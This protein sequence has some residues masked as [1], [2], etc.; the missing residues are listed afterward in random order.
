MP[1]QDYEKTEQFRQML[2]Q[3]RTGLEAPPKPPLGSRGRRKT[4]SF[5][6]LE[7]SFVEMPRNLHAASVAV[8][9]Q[10][11][12][13]SASVHP[14]L[15]KR[16]LGTQN[17]DWEDDRDNAG[18]AE[19]D[20]SESG[21][22]DAEGAVSFWLTPKAS[23]S[24]LEHDEWLV[25]DAREPEPPAPATTAAPAA[26]A[27]T[28][29]A[30]PAATV[31]AGNT[32]TSPEQREA[33]RTLLAKFKSDVLGAARKVGNQNMMERRG[34]AAA[35]N[36]TQK[37]YQGKAAA[38][39][40]AL[41]EL[42]R[43]VADGADGE[44][45]R[46]MSVNNTQ[47]AR[48]MLQQSLT[49]EMDKKIHFTIVETVKNLLEQPEFKAILC[50]YSLSHKLDEPANGKG[51][52][53][54]LSAGALMRRGEAAQYGEEGHT[55]TATGAAA[56]QEEAAQQR[57][58]NY[59]ALQ[60]QLEQMPVSQGMLLLKEFHQ[61]VCRCADEDSCR[62]SEAG[63][64]WCFVDNSTLVGCKIE[65]VKLL[66]DT[67]NRTWS[68][69]LCDKRPC[70]PANLGMKPKPSERADLDTERHPELSNNNTLI[71]YGSYCDTWKKT[72]K[73]MWAYV[74]FDT[75]CVERTRKL[76]P[77]NGDFPPGLPY[78]FQSWT[79]CT[80][81]KL[82]DTKR[83]DGTVGALYDVKVKC[84]WYQTVL[85]CFIIADL[86]FTV[87]MMVIMYYFIANRCADN[88]E[89]EESTLCLW[90]PNRSPSPRTRRKRQPHLLLLL[91]LL[92]RPKAF[93]IPAHFYFEVDA[94]V[95]GTGLPESI[96]AAALARAG[97][98][99]LH[100]D[101]SEN[102]GGPWR[103]LPLR[104]YASWAGGRATM[105]GDGV[106]A[107]G[108]FRSLPPHA[109]SRLY[110]GF[111]APAAECGRP[112]EVPA[113][114]EA[115]EATSSMKA[116]PEGV[117]AIDLQRPASCFEDRSFD[118]DPFDE[119]FGYQLRQMQNDLL[120]SPTSF[121]L[122]L[123]P[124]LLY[125][126]SD[127]VDVLIESG[128]ARYLE[129]QGLKFTRVLTSNG[130]ASVPLTKSEI[131]QDAH[132]SKAEKRLLMRFITSIQPFVSSL[133]FQS[134]A[135]LGVDQ[136]GKVK[137][138]ADADALKA[139]N[140][141][142]DSS[143]RSFLE[144]QSL[145]ER[146]QDFITYSICLWDWPS[147]HLSCREALGRMGAFIS[148]LGLYGRGTT[149]PLLFPMYGV[150]EVA[151]GFTRLC[152]VHR[153]L[154]ALRTYATHV[155]TETEKGVNEE[156][157]KE[158][159]A[160]TAAAAAAVSS[161]HRACGIVTN[162]GE[163]VRAELVVAGCEDFLQEAPVSSASTHCRRCTV[164]LD[165]P[166]LGEEGVSLCVVPPT[167]LDPPLEN[168]VQVLQLD[169][170]SG[171]CPRN[172]FLAHLSQSAEG[173]FEDLDR[174]LEVL[175]CQASARC[176]FR[177]IKACVRARC[178]YVHRPREKRRWNC[179]TVAG[180]VLQKLG[181]KASKSTL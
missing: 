143:W 105:P 29:T 47:L 80:G 34:T 67:N 178:R 114:P 1:D 173:A 172:V 50:V 133:A 3:M 39:G 61:D 90:T 164:L 24:L 57:Q 23:P 150:G 155:L 53:L 110:R 71:S 171:A 158:K 40:R 122:D 140:L 25:H 7:E 42:G 31:Q 16:L 137:P 74:G 13:R 166:L 109:W 147:E 78:M 98:K 113:A 83:P 99:V 43:S 168:V 5:L 156:E 151:Q 58:T 44:G 118:W 117:N 134:A 102:Y 54:R 72:D 160:T 95:L 75:T 152:A 146:L 48:M 38:V 45:G 86:M 112:A 27:A 17:L 174:V 100:L 177:R 19:T 108:D 26:T 179:G 91:L 30:A 41:M 135:Q 163:V 12:V 142:L 181:R 20:R 144:K 129:F 141:D 22:G 69:D 123:T 161:S 79:A 62:R 28:S 10:E 149:M 9:S 33:R 170:S 97:K 32:T 169:F 96:C 35:E 84:M 104:E 124:R 15:P 6:E 116:L 120:R 176:I 103:S 106:K 8:E 145:S 49:K 52:M 153:G 175:R 59:G 51:I 101:A 89:V 132:L 64:S 11:S 21:S 131:F 127:E 125:G 66:K 165:R 138:A 107:F 77:K 55:R 154:Y 87:P 136:A 162:R 73:L 139:L 167:A 70:E 119:L 63:Q 148:S 81:N 37:T 46:Q 82:W 92:R 115:M 60:E 130:L 159:E 126:R 93:H 157:E 85:E 56:G 128:V 76:V 94:V 180:E 68:Y 18:R 36:C 121:S 4:E 111:G 2:E 14:H 65:G 88:F